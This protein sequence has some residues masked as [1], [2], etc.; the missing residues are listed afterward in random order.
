MSVVLSD[1]EAAAL[2]PLLARERHRARTNGRDLPVFLLDVLGRLVAAE[3][4]ARRRPVPP[5]AS[6]GSNRA[7]SLAMVE[8]LGAVE[9]AERAGV[10]RRAVVKA[11][12]QGRL[13]GEL[14]DA[15]WRFTE[16]DA[17][18]WMG[19]RVVAV[20]VVDPLAEMRAERAAD[21]A[22]LTDLDA[23]LR[24]QERLRDVAA[25]DEAR[26][27][28]QGDVV[29]GWKEA[30]KVAAAESRIAELVAERRPL[31]ER[32]NS[33]AARLAPKDQARAELV[34]E[35]VA[36]RAEVCM[37]SIQARYDALADEVERELI[38]LARESGGKVT[39]PKHLRAM[40]KV[41]G[42]SSWESMQYQLRCGNRAERIRELKELA[43]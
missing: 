19:A 40:P 10:T 32:R 34:T 4:R 18:T 20:T 33:L 1:A 22:R 3:G 42:S 31:Q 17:V 5:V 37:V 21:E 2:A 26:L 27:T 28:K 30:A 39:V 12:E 25:I 35:L 11:A 9:V 16:S 8:T 24:E 38:P 13:R 15:G 6:A 29:G 23:E 36:E 7:V 41:K 14:T 43:K